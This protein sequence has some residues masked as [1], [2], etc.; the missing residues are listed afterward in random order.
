M[1]VLVAGSSPA[2]FLADVCHLSP[3]HSN[4]PSDLA[5]AP[6]RP[7]GRETASACR[8][9]RTQMSQ[10]FRQNSVGSASAYTP[11]LFHALWISG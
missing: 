8:D 5:D 6:P 7:P 10:R 4:S 11:E 9:S 1:G 2:L 3:P